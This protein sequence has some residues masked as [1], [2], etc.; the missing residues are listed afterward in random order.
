MSVFSFIFGNQAD[1]APMSESKGFRIKY[2][3]EA[4]AD[5]SIEINDLAPALLAVSDL[6]QE[7]NSLANRGDSKISVKVKATET[8]CFQIY[9]EAARMTVTD[10]RDLLTGP[11]V[12]AL[13][14]LLVL[15]EFVE[16]P[17]TVTG[18]ITFIKK[19]CGKAPK[20]VTKIGDNEFEI[21]TESG[22]VKISKLEWDMYQNQKIRQAVYN[23]LKPLERDG[24]ETFESVDGEKTISKIT[25]SELQ[26]FLPPSERQEPLPELPARETFVNIVHMWFKDGDNKWKFSEGLY[27]QS[28]HIRSILVSAKHKR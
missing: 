6:I 22:P 9:I 12:S 4:L 11:N 18:L 24:V 8:G 14:A 21:E 25:K 13:V 1:D 16:G 10:F 23:I 15:L 5:H 20:K 17:T 7:A 27:N 2:N 26:Y 28:R 3:G 19:L